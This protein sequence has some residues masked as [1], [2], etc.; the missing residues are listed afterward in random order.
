MSSGVEVTV[1]S[2]SSS[3]TTSDGFFYNSIIS[4]ETVTV[5]TRRLLMAHQALAVS[6]SLVLEGTSALVVFGHYG[7]TYVTDTLILEN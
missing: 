2:Q 3:G 6:G 5:P 1:E 7:N 4:S